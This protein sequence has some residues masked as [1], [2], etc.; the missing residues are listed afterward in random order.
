[1]E[2]MRQQGGDEGSV[3]FRRALSELRASEL[4][5]ESWEL[6]CTR[7]TNQLPPTEVAAFETALWLYF[8]NEEVRNKNS[9]KIIAI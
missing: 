9:E 5:K 3:R 7:V 1:M 8:I 4:S 6:F 2:V